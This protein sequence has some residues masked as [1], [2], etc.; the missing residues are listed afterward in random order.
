MY[1]VNSLKSKDLVNGVR[2]AKIVAEDEKRRVFKPV[3]KS[4]EHLFRVLVC[5]SI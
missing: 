3:I 1:T 4:V 2:I 5:F